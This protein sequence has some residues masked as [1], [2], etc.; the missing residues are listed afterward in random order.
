MVIACVTASRSSTI[1]SLVTSFCSSPSTGRSMVETRATRP[2]TI[3]VNNVVV[4]QLAARLMLRFALSLRYL[5]PLMVM[6]TASTTTSK[7]LMR[8]KAV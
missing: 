7:L 1:P 8:R 4:S 5:R 2:S 3:R 6:I